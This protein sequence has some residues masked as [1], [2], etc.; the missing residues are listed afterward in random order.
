MTFFLCFHQLSLLLGPVRLHHLAQAV[1]TL[2]WCCGLQGAEVDGSARPYSEVPGRSGMLSSQNGPQC[3]I[4]FHKELGLLFVLFQL[5]SIGK[6]HPLP[7][8]RGEGQEKRGSKD[9][10]CIGPLSQN[11]TQGS[12]VSCVSSCYP[13]IRLRHL[14]ARLG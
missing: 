7:G 9:L 2:S 6:N 10:G 13:G 1:W 8:G 14:S 12:L 4:C 11:H 5:F 3:S